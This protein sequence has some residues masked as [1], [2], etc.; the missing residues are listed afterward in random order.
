[1]DAT[2]DGVLGGY[3]TVNAKDVS[4]SN[5]FIVE[6]LRECLPARKHNLVALG[7]ARC[8]IALPRRVCTAFSSQALSC[9]QIAA[10]A[11]VESHA[12]CCYDTSVRCAALLMTSPPCNL[13]WHVLRVPPG[14]HNSRVC[15]P[16]LN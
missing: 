10:L 12:I 16:C 11:W 8:P 14:Q 2:V 5:R 6:V 13:L 9:L 1:M 7:G 15:C 3:G 4:D